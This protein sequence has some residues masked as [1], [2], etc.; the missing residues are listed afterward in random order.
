MWCVFVYIYIYILYIILYI[1]ILYTPFG[2]S[3]KGMAFPPENVSETRKKS[4][5]RIPGSRTE[6]HKWP[7]I[8]VMCWTEQTSEFYHPKMVVKQLI[9]WHVLLWWFDKQQHLGSPI[10]RGGSPINKT[11]SIMIMAIEVSGCI[12]H[13]YE[14]IPI[15][16]PKCCW[17]DMPKYW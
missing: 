2:W 12:F 15:D 5:G 3:M 14:I 6:N 1:Y 8:C 11:V 17:F 10:S 9:M 7:R 4:S 13:S 16:I